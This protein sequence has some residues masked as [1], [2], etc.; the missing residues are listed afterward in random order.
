MELN[1]SEFCDF[2]NRFLDKK[3][4]EIYNNIGNFEV[5]YLP[6]NMTYEVCFINQINM[7]SDIKY[8]IQFP[9]DFGSI[10][11][12]AVV[13]KERTPKKKTK[14]NKKHSRS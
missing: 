3:K 7:H 1:N 10:Q 13:A 14:E 2:F 6:E 9:I 8:S 12:F 5:K 11:V 4:D